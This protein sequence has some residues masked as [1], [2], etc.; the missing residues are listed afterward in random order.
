MRTLTKC[1]CVI[2]IAGFPVFAE[3][4]AQD[5]TT[6]YQGR[7]IKVIVGTGTGGGYDTYARLLTRHLGKHIPGNPSFVV[8]YMPGASGIKA[9]NFL[10]SVAPKDGT[11]IATFNNSMPVYQAINQPGIQFK[12]EEL[13]WV[14]SMSKLVNVVAVWHTSGAK[15][16]E[17]TKRIEII[18][19]ATGAG[20]TMAGYPT[21]LNNTLGTK[22]KVITGYE[23]G[24]AINLAMERGELQGRGNLS[25]SSMHS[26]KPDWLSENK[27]IPIVQ[28]GPQKEKDL[29]HVPLLVELAQNDEQR[30]IFEFVS[31]INAIERP[32]AG[33]P[34]VPKSRLDTLR[35]G[36]DMTVRD[37][38]FIAEA[39]KQDVQLDPSSGED[40]EILILQLAN[41]PPAVVAKTQ[42]AMGGY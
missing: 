36:F 25:W 23:G 12:T 10:Y 20:G 19:G 7:Q 32:F 18:M 14:G 8:Q 28:I 29:Q 4:Q 2:S 6:F 41:V 15:T 5:N 3:A 13:S 33:P 27:I 17:D 22:F 34:G 42:A 30:Q 24:N 40:V 1:L 39:A 16:I 35:R 11:A 38:A 37:S 9:V 31:A 26:V 21:L